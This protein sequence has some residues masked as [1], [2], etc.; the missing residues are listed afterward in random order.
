MV[1]RA[2]RLR[3]FKTDGYPGSGQSVQALTEDHVGTYIL[4]FPCERIDG[5]WRNAITGE[6]VQANIL[7]WREVQTE[8]RGRTSPAHQLTKG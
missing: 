2:A 7:G 1:I 4:P 6:A 8:S 5:E 3:D